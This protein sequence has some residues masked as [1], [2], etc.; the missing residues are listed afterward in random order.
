MQKLRLALRGWSRRREEAKKEF[1]A[2]NTAW[3]SGGQA[4]PPVQSPHATTA[5][6]IDGLTVAYLDDSG[7]FAHYLDTGT[8]DIVDVASNQ[9]LDAPRYR[10]VP[11]RTAQSESADRRAFVDG[12]QPSRGRDELARAIGVPEAFRKALSNDRALERA[13]YSFKN[14]RAIAAIESWLKNEGGGAQGAGRR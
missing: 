8:G 14:D 13:W 10:R 7:H 6:D 12:L 2:Q 9:T 1:L 5:I 3:R 4:P 11:Q